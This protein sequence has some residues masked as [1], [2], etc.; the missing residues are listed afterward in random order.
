MSINYKYTTTDKTD[1]TNSL[2]QT[3]A[4]DAP[5]SDKYYGAEIVDKDKKQVKLKEITDKIVKDFK[6]DDTTG[7]LV[8][9]YMDDSKDEIDNIARNYDVVEVPLV[10]KN[11]TTVKDTSIPPAILDISDHLLGGKGGMIFTLDGA[12]HDYGKWHKVIASV[13][14]SD[15]NWKRVVPPSGEYY[16]GM[17]GYMENATYMLGGVTVTLYDNGDVKIWL[18]EGGLTPSDVTGEKFTMYIDT[19]VVAR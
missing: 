17:I 9:E 2:K 19:F 5:D 1:V 15:A 7:K 10:M 16:K 13:D 14:T 4:L 18:P 12:A 11:G 3:T 8:L 6:Y